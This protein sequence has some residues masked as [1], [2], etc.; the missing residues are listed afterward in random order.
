[1]SVVRDASTYPTEVIEGANTPLP[2][3]LDAHHLVQTHH[4]RRPAR[5][6][7]T[8][9]LLRPTPT[10]SASNPSLPQKHL[11]VVQDISKLLVVERA[12]LPALHVAKGPV[13][14]VGAGVLHQLDGAL[15]EV[16][17]GDVLHLLVREL[18]RHDLLDPGLVVDAGRSMPAV[19]TIE[20]GAR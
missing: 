10:V 15:L 19:E 14:K 17:R 11:R 18:A 4:A 7:G 16:A 8:S 1:M 5:P 3:L 6:E 13:R 12:I 2:V 9:W 20:L